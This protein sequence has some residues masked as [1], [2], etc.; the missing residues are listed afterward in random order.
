MLLGVTLLAGQALSARL[1]RDAME[2]RGG[3]VGGPQSGES[4]ECCESVLI[5]WKMDVISCNLM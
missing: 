4:G 5:L 2:F 1:R 3:K